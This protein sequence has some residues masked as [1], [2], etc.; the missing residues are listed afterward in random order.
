MTT[1]TYGQIFHFTHIDNLP[2]IIAANALSCDARISRSGALG[3]EAGNPQIKERR[4]SRAV[5]CAPWGTVADYVPFYYA[6][7]SPMMFT[8]AKGNVPTFTGD[9]HDLVYFTSHVTT[10]IEAG[11]PWVASD[12]NAAVAVA[13]FT[14][15]PAVFDCLAHPD[16]A[17]GF[18]DW[19]LMNRTYWNSVPNDPDRMERRM[20]EFLVHDRVPLSV[21]T[22]LAVHSPRQAGIVER[23]FTSVDGLD[24]IEVQP[25]WYY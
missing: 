24:S 6:A 9:H 16:P 20:A 7:R 15:D 4:R 11:L 3:V 1:P 25:G 10:I 5:A 8:I 12:R 22:S 19:P 21:I 2:S 17:A 14:N 23:L 18:V 13:D